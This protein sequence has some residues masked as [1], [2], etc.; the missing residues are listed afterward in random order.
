MWWVQDFFETH[1]SDASAL[2]N[3]KQLTKHIHK[4][5]HLRQMPD[6]LKSAAGVAR[7][8]AQRRLQHSRGVKRKLRPE[9][10]PLRVPLRPLGPPTI[11][12]C[13]HLFRCVEGCS[14]FRI[15]VQRGLLRQCESRHGLPHSRIVA[16]HAHKLLGEVPS[17]LLRTTF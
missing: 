14:C 1:E 7:G 5:K 16:S 4:V 13:M 17:P 3:D 2:K 15:P 12:A 6:Y 11:F 9:D 10:D 8:G